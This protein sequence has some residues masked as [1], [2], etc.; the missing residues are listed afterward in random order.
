MILDG[1]AGIKFLIEGNPKHFF[2]VIKAHGSYY[3]MLPSTIKKRKEMKTKINFKNTTTG[4]LNLN[5]V[6]RFF[7]K[8]QKTFTEIN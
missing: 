2:A 3:C 7:I 4:I 1:V 6:Y 5:T 8:K